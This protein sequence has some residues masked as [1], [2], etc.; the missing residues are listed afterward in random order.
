M[1]V[2]VLY[3][4]WEDEP[5]EVEEEVPAPRKGKGQTKRKKKPV[6]HD[7]EEIFEALEKLGHEPSYYVLDGRPQS[8]I[9]L[10]KCGADLIFNLTE[11]YAGDDTKE[12]H[13]TAFLDM[14]DIPYT[15]AGPHAN[16]L[17]QDKSIAKKMF[18][19]YGI[20]SPYFATAYPGTIDRAQREQIFSRIQF[21]PAC[22]LRRHVSN[23]AHRGPRAG[24]VRGAG[25]VLCRP[26]GLHRYLR[27]R[28]FGQSEIQHLHRSALGQKNI[29]RL[30]VAMD[31]T[32]RVRRIERIRQL[33]PPIQQPVHARRAH[34]QLMKERLALQQL[35]GNKRLVARSLDR[36]NRAD[37]GMVQPR[38]SA[39]FRQKAVQRILIAREFRRQKLQRQP[40]PQIE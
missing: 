24:Q 18:A 34:I 1:K 8:L 21:P 35:H 29:C 33:N 17:A 20:Q 39:R 30:D 38:S 10:S 25:I 31:N 23:R 37:V 19:F 16:T 22:L 11:S 3:D 6:K 26:D 28:Q 32:F 9:G 7:R 4:L 14:I 13:V 40:A 2:T 12:M 15:G 36:I 27:T 5:A